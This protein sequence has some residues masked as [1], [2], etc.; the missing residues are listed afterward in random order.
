MPRSGK[1][2]SKHARPTP[3]QHA[4]SHLIDPHNDAPPPCEQLIRELFA[5]WHN[6]QADLG[7]LYNCRLDEPDKQPLSLGEAAALWRSRRK[8]RMTAAVGAPAQ[9][10]S[11]RK[12]R[13]G[14][15]RIVT[16]RSRRSRMSRKH[17]A[18]I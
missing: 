4:A 16:A 1:K 12:G 6:T 10:H 9:A 18:R 11:K 2:P 17:A 3:A 5:V 14:R 15:K 13:K 8:Y 7:C